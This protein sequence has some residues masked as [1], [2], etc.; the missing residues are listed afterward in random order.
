MG[1]LQ[2]HIKKRYNLKNVK[3]ESNSYPERA[4]KAF[5]S[6]F[7]IDYMTKYNNMIN[8]TK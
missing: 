1:V 5:R 6:T 3:I 4:D 8:K 7:M 2:N